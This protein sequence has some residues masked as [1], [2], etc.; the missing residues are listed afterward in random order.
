[1]TRVGRCPQSAGVFGG[2]WLPGLASAPG[3]GDVLRA[4]CCWLPR[5]AVCGKR[6]D[7]FAGVL[8]QCRIMTGFELV[9]AAGVQLMQGLAQRLTAARPDLAGAGASYGELAWTWARGA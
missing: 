7:G 2:M 4:L 8:A 9:T 3:N 5:S 6:F 1:M